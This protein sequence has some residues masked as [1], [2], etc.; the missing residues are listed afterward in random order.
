MQI[1]FHGIQGLMFAHVLQALHQEVKDK[2]LTVVVDVRS[3][4][5][6][7]QL[8]LE[9]LGFFPTA[10]YPS[11]ISYGLRRVDAVQYTRLFNLCFEENLK[12]TN[13]LNWFFR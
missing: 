3:D 13:N 10:Y 11:L 7:L 1:L 9:K 6:K 12:C 8:T 2:P 4:N 5:K